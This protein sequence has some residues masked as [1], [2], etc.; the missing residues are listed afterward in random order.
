EPEAGVVDVVI[1]LEGGQRRKL[2]RVDLSPDPGQ[3]AE[4][5]GHRLHACPG[6]LGLHAGRR[7]GRLAE[8]G[9]GGVGLLAL[10]VEP[11]TRHEAVRFLPDEGVGPFQYE[12]LEQCLGR[13]ADDLVGRVGIPLADGTADRAAGGVGPQRDQRHQRND[14]Q[15][16]ERGPDRPL[17]APAARNLMA[18]LSGRL[19]RASYPAH[20]RFRPY[21]A[22]GTVDAAAAKRPPR[23]EWSPV[24]G[25]PLSGMPSTLAAEGPAIQGNYRFVNT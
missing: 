23:R 21:R 10:R 17:T 2:A 9:D 6:H 22:E 11:G 3:L 7:P 5:P 15:D 20:R 19:P 24:P 25:G 13:G 18:R 16:G 1:G 4:A 14:Q 12:L 8:P